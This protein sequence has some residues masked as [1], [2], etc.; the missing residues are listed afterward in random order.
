VNKSPK[1][2]TLNRDTMRTLT[3]ASLGD[4][5]GG[6]TQTICAVNI[7]SCRVSVCNFNTYLVNCVAPGTS[8]AC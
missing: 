5:A 6:A 7:F 1:T 2:L 3:S 8:N 4:V